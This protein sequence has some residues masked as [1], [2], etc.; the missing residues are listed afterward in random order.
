M[1]SS[2]LTTSVLVVSWERPELLERL[3]RS[4]WQQIRLPTEIVVCWQSDDLPTYLNLD[5]LRSC[6]SIPCPLV[7]VHLAENGIVPAENLALESSAGDLILMIDDDAIAPPDWI[8]RIVS[9]HDSHPL[10]GAFGGPADCWTAIGERLPINP[11]KPVAG[12]SWLGRITTNLHDQ[13]VEWRLQ[14]P[15]RVDHLVGY[16]LSL[17]RSAFDRFEDRL[18]PY[19]QL[20]ELDACLTASSRGF[21]IWFDP[22]L[23]VEHRV[24]YSTG[25]YAPGREGDWSIRFENS[26]YNQALVLSKHTKGFWKRQLRW[27]YLIFVGTSSTPGPLLIPLTIYMHGRVLREIRLSFTCSVSKGRGWRLGRTL[28]PDQ[29]RT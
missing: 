12:L 7:I 8:D 3:I 14:P 18:K 26:S 23:V 1:K 20:F 21:E 19:W 24:G 2:L 22:D 27:L 10:C 25:V 29:A 6:P 28:K 17:K 9:F 5:Q 4:L 15:H 11:R 13:P 16:N